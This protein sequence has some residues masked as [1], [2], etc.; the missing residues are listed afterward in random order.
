MGIIVLNQCR[1][2]SLKTFHVLPAGHGRLRVPNRVQECRRLILRYHLGDD[3][4]FAPADQDRAGPRNSSR[5]FRKA[6]HR[7]ATSRANSAEQRLSRSASSA[8]SQSECPIPWLFLCNS[9]C[10]P[11][12]HVTNLVVLLPPPPPVAIASWETRCLTLVLTRARRITSRQ[13][14]G[15]AFRRAAAVQSFPH[16]QTM[17]RHIGI[18]FEA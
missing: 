14:R 3:R 9:S 7:V 11:S 5:C 15:G 17:D 16:L 12:L 6:S 2:P 8:H 4:H 13:R 1:S 18:D 10:S